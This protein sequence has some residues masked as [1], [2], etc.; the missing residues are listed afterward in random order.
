[1]YR[2]LL[3]EKVVFIVCCGGLCYCQMAM[4]DE[5][6]WEVQGRAWMR[7]AACGYGGPLDF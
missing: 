5:G 2:S 6:L 7:K 1:M 4:M 3:V